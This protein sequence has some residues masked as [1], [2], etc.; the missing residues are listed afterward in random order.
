MNQAGTD[1]IGAKLTA[2]EN[3]PLDLESIVPD[4]N[5]GP[6]LD[7]EALKLLETNFIWPNFLI[8][9]KNSSHVITKEEGAAI[10]LLVGEY[11]WGYEGGN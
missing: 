11:D 5:T 9:K 8:Q 6:D 2:A 4:C 10:D 1:K 7:F 3:V